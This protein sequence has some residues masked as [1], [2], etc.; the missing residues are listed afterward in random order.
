[1]GLRLCAKPAV[2]ASI[3]PRA[4]TAE[5][6]DRQKIMDD[7]SRQVGELL[8][9]VGL[10]GKFVLLDGIMDSM[11][12]SDIKQQARDEVAKLL[13]KEFLSTELISLLPGDGMDTLKNEVQ[14]ED[15]RGS[16]GLR[17]IVDST[18]PCS[19]FG[20]E[21]SDQHFEG[22][23]DSPLVSALLKWLR[24]GGAAP[25]RG[26]DEEQKVV[27]RFMSLYFDI[28]MKVD[29][30]REQGFKDEDPKFHFGLVRSLCLDV[31]KFV[32]TLQSK[33]ACEQ[34]PCNGTAS[35]SLMAYCSRHRECRG[36]HGATVHPGNCTLSGLSN[37]LNPTM[38]GKCSGSIK[39]SEHAKKLFKDIECCSIEEMVA[40]KTCSAD[41]CLAEFIGGGAQEVPTCG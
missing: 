11:T 18:R 39:D 10:S 6:F 17:V 37:S 5:P 27:S 22:G 4:V 36:C 30:V 32:K 3:Q 16:S 38:Q 40:L 14:M 1:M 24:E 19:V 29:L 20:L 12:V 13:N 34:L 28:S 21:L 15:L 8:L 2:A 7:Q 23:M 31:G 25:G 9:Q 35:I 33:S 26:N 41:V